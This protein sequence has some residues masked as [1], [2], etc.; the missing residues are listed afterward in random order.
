MNKTQA[1]IA[2]TLRRDIGAHFRMISGPPTYTDADYWNVRASAD[3]AQQHARYLAQ[4]LVNL[5][6]DAFLIACG[7]RPI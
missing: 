5:D 2:R 4:H 3:L 6:S 7:V 1:R